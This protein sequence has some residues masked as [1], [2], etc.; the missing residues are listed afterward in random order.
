MFTFL[1]LIRINNPASVMMQQSGSVAS[2]VM[3]NTATTEL[4]PRTPHPA[5]QSGNFT[6]ANSK[7]YCFP[8]C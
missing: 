7:R 6:P 5:S 3:T 2:S 4:Q 8:Y 1:G